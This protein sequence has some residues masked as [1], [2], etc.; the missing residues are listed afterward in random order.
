MDLERFRTWLGLFLWEDQAR[1]GMEAYRY[2][3][4]LSIRGEAS[5]YVL[6]GV[7]DTFE[8]ELGPTRKPSQGPVSKLVFIGKCLDEAYFRTQL[9]SLV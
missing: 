5:Q 6:Q 1:L 8:L 2:K 3:G 9:K 4:L 7:H